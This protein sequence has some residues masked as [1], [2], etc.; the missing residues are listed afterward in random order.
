MRTTG[1]ALLAALTLAS[2]ADDS[3]NTNTE[4]TPGKSTSSAATAS[5]AMTTSAP[6]SSPPST[7]TEPERA[8][9]TPDVGEHA[10]DVGEPRAGLEVT[11][12]LLE[13]SDPYPPSQHRRPD[14][15]NRFVGLIL[16]TCVKKDA[17]ATAMSTHQDE[18]SFVDEA[19]NNWTDAGPNWVN[20]PQPTYPTYREV[21]PGQCVQGWLAVSLPH[22]VRPVTVQ[23]VPQ[24]T[25]VADWRL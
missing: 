12:T 22:D 3:G 15:G 8:P 13:V 23:W 19:G 9:G 18:F 20:F 6:G 25:H 16:R 1:L 14:P 24:G 11:T 21:L 10:L 17:S 5:E 7:S 2:C 4:A